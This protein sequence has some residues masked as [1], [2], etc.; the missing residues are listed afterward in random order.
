MFQSRITDS[1]KNQL[2]MVGGTSA[3]KIAAFV[4][5]PQRRGPGA[6][7]LGPT[8]ARLRPRA[9]TPRAASWSP[10]RSRRGRTARGRPA[11]VEPAASSSQPRPRGQPQRR[12]PAPAPASVE[13][14]QPR[15]V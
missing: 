4:S 9:F 12:S 14:N 11:A 2:T 1:S 8:Q 15:R 3:F 10:W 7:G 6:L 5:I 13:P